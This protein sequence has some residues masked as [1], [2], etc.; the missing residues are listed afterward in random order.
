MNGSHLGMSQFA[1]RL[2]FERAQAE[3]SGK[4]LVQYSELYGTPV[5]GQRTTVRP[6]DHPDTIFVTNTEWA[7][8]SAVQWYNEET[9]I[10]E[11]LNSRYVPQKLV[12][13]SPFGWVG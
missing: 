6:I 2:D 4:K 10:F 12:N 8:T 7:S 13:P 5:V 11:T 9:G 3:H 1:T